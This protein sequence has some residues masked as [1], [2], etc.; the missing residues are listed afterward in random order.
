[1]KCSTVLYRQGELFA[2]FRVFLIL[3]C[4]VS[5]F[6]PAFGQV[7]VLTQHNDNSRT[8]ANLAETILNTSNVNQANFGKVFTCP[9]DG[10]I[11]AQPLYVS[12][13]TINGASHNVVFVATEHDSVYALD[14][15][16][17]VQL[18]KTSLGQSV[19]STD[20]GAGYHDLTP[21]IGIT[22]TPVID[23][24]TN[25]L[26]VDA[27][28]KDA[29][30]AYHHFLHALDITKGSDKPGSPVEV[31]GTVAGSSWD[32]SNGQL[33]FNPF[34]H[35]QRPALLLS[36]GT[37]YVCFGSHG[38]FEPYHGWVFTYNAAT[39]AREGIFC[40]SPNGQ[41]GGIWM[42]GQGPVA[43]AQGNIYFMVGNTDVG[44]E[45]N[46]EDYGESFV[47]LGLSANGLSELDYF[48]ANN[49]DSLNAADADLG[50]AGPMLL[51]G[52]HNLVGGGKQG[53]IYQVDTTNMGGLDLNQ[54]QVV[55]EFQASNPEIVQSPVYWNSPVSGPTIYVWGAYGDFLKAYNMTGGFFNTSPYSEETTIQSPGLP[56]GCLS[57]SANGSTAGTG[58]IWATH[59]VN[60]DANQSIV[61]GEL[62]AFDA[63]DL[64]KVLWTSLQNQGRDDVGNVAKFVPPTIANGKVY[65]ATFSKQLDVYG[66]FPIPS[67]LLPN[68]VTVGSPSFML[69]VNGS[70]FESNSVVNWNGSPLATTF[71][72]VTQL[73]ATVPGSDVASIIPVTVTVSN[74]GGSR[75]NGLPFTINPVP[76]A[77]LTS[78][79]PN[80]ATVG[81]TGFTITI[82]GTGFLSGATTQ[83]NSTQLATTFLSSTQVTAVVPTADLAVLKP[84]SVTVTNP[85]AVAS[86]ALPFTI[87]PIHMFAA[88]LQMFSV[89]YDYSAVPLFLA[90]PYPNPELAVWVSQ[91]DRY[92][93]T[94]AAPADVLRLGQAYWVRFPQAVPLATP[95][96]LASTTK[97]FIISLQEGWNM[98]GDPFPSA[99]D[100]STLLVEEGNG[101]EMSFQQAVQADLVSSTLYSYPANGP[102]YISQTSGALTPFSGY[103]MLATTACYILVPPPAGG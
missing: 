96:V 84:V 53:V 45:N 46:S 57:I 15:D 62:D 91:R 4:S 79:S 44:F 93:L 32:S 41:E 16:T 37:L 19:P 2:L 98:I 47:K 5:W 102:T 3:L 23:L 103:W 77:T 17:G 31:T 55:Q 69:T 49:Y 67:G 9:V 73:T 87:N 89:P 42:G 39:L 30:N 83:W 29:N 24:S 11:Y 70:G 66:L 63:T 20:Y 64:T 22:G 8:G 50:S 65:I 85:N 68:S 14:G 75:S 26:Y 12:N 59:S 1:M 56:G 36:N 13:L 43:D 40:S 72:S 33:V 54:D 21:E 60:G 52:T 100:I 35:L 25:T 61:H 82:D 86:N 34:Q 97:P 90:L 88:G 18:W 6:T 94:P 80:S 71:V 92:N 81:A 74:P 38:D 28:T 51:P 76:P 7:E 27:F 58:I 78:I 48:K 95:G 99:V 10:Y 101:K